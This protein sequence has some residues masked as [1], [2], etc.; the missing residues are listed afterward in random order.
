ME[1][2]NI[3]LFIVWYCKEMIGSLDE[4][5]ICDIEEIFEYVIKLENCKEEIICL[6]D[7]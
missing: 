3:V 4:V 7:E 5:E 2:G 1:E 6:I